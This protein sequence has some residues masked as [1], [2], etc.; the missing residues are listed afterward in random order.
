MNKQEGKISMTVSIIITI[1]LVGF[2]VYAF[3]KK[4]VQAPGK[5]Q[6][7]ENEQVSNS[8]KIIE[9]NP[10]NVLSPTKK[11]MEEISKNGDVLSMNYTGRLTNGTVFDSNVDPKFGHVQPFE[12]ILGAGQVI[13][14]WD[15]GLVGM[16]VG[17][18]KTLNIPAEKA[19]GARGAGDRIPP[20]SDLI[21]EVE[22]VAI[23]K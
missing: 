17:E 8:E 22:L 3:A 10:E 21:F 12:F 5:A 14:G 2:V 16:K 18:K 19:Y 13:K 7:T 6:I 15:E 20:N 4:E 1:I 9:E 11:S 23:K